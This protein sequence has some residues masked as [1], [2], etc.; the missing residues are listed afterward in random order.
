MTEPASQSWE[1]A[2]AW[3]KRQPDSQGLV[4]ACFYDD[5]LE[6]AAS[7]YY[8]S[9]EWAAV[10]ALLPKPPGSALDIGAGR[11]ISSYAL[12]KDRWQVTA[13]EPDSSALVGAGAI[14]QLATDAGLDIAVVE[15]WGE[16]LPFPDRHF[17]LVHCRQVLHHAR[18]LRALCKEIA[19]VLK[20]H[21]S[22]IATREHVISQHNDLQR[23]LDAHPLHRLYGGEHA[24]RLE[25]Y[26][27][28]ITE[29]GIRIVKQFNPYASD[30]NLYPKTRAELK[31]QLCDR[32][33]WPFPKLIPDLGLSLLGALSNSPGRL[34]SF[35]GKRVGDA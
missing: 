26:R 2:V 25:D 23:F 30:I 20:P 15:N 13:L 31:Q 1:S 21:G 3:L 33:H 4:E 16:S 34:Y 6:R 27:A 19:R 18:D 9:R 28:A 22:F 11:G 10:R 5:P 17:D 35:F 32:M 12:A 29:T 24:Y 7:R 8:A 14:R